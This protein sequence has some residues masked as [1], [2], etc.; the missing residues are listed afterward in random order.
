MTTTTTTWGLALLVGLLLING[1][2]ARESDYC[3][4]YESYPYVSMA[5]KTAYQFAHGKA[6][7]QPVPSCTPIQIW[8][9]ARHGTRYPDSADIG[10]LVSLS[11]LRDQILYNHETRG[12]GRMCDQDL[13]RLR[14]W[15]PNPNM[16]EFNAD[17]LTEQG[18]EDMRLFAKRL[19]SYFPELL[20]T[21]LYSVSY[22]SFK[23]RSTAT[24]RTQA[25]ME[26][27][28]EGLFGRV[29]VIPPEAIPNPDNLLRAYKQCPAW[30]RGSDINDDETSEKFKFVSG[31]EYQ[32]LLNNV[33]SRLGFA[34]AI[35]NDS[36]QLMYDM[37]RYDKAWNIAELSPWCSVF[38]KQEL[39]ILEYTEDLEEYYKSGP[40]REV[41]S[42]LGCPLLNDMFDHFKNLER[43]NFN[44]EPRG[45]FYFAHSTTLLNLLSSLDIRKDTTPLLSH[46]YHSMERR[47]FKT[48]EI[49]AFASNLVAVFY[50]CSELQPNKV[51]FF[52]NEQPVYL[53]G[54]SVGL[55]DWEY[56]KGRFGHEADKCNLDYCYNVAS[57]SFS[58]L[59]VV[60]STIGLVLSMRFLGAL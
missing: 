57:S 4:S 23:F 50:R 59:Q 58:I 13:Q 41:N 21:N 60:Y 46:N 12:H 49:D 5:T 31:P 10:R 53:D 22:Q 40:G 11:K 27:F 37:C 35:H 19:Q 2:A 55:C 48:S 6:R 30:L 25:S 15:R 14:N 17:L 51:M 52:L 56:L 29:N 39:M 28:M 24:Q 43:G 18:N 32:N 44:N 8:I 7:L 36:I 34:Y 45:I 42:K 20:R 9:L 33:S 38:S 26:A 3:Y 1:T 54:C 47:R 16:I